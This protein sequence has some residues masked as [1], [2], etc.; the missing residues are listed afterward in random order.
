MSEVKLTGGR[1]NY[2]LVQVVAPQREEQPP[3]QAECE[4]IIEEL[5]LNPDEAN[6]FKEIWRS[7]RA[8]Q[9]TGKPGH[10]ALYGAEKIVHYAGRILRRLKRNQPEPYTE[11]ECDQYHY[12]EPYP[13]PGYKLTP[14]LE[15]LWVSG[16]A[17]AADRSA[18]IQQIKKEL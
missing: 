3:Y 9:A 14:S 11:Q 15:E 12:G 1:V 16:P 7:A 13:K 8:R 10:T 18:H 2:Y 4:D 17:G 5:E 6:I